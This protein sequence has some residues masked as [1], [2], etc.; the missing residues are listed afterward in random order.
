M[1]TSYVY[2]YYTWGFRLLYPPPYKSLL[3]SRGP[4]LYLVLSRNK[5]GSKKKNC[6]GISGRSL[7]LSMLYSR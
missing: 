7:L 1:Y 5:Y 3:L 6:L 2:L 4:V